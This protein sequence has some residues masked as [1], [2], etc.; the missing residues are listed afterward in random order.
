MWVKARTIV[1]HSL[2][3]FLAVW[4]ILCLQE[5]SKSISHQDNKIKFNNAAAALT[6]DINKLLFLYRLIFFVKTEILFSVIT[7]SVI[8]LFIY[9]YNESSFLK[10]SSP[11]PYTQHVFI[12]CYSEKFFNSQRG[13][14]GPNAFKIYCSVFLRFG[15]Q[16]IHLWTQCPHASANKNSS[17]SIPYNL[18]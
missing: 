15:S 13:V 9:L 3:P 18:N 11:N 12:V 1:L 6:K 2:F 16:L 14:W 7:I 10:L 17:E 8:I 4:L 5:P